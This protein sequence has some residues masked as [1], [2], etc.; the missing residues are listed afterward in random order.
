MDICKFRWCRWKTPTINPIWKRLNVPFGLD[1]V[2]RCTVRT[3]D[4]VERSFDPSQLIRCVS[5]WWV[6]IQKTYFVELKFQK[7]FRK[8]DLI[9]LSLSRC[10]QK[11][12]SEHFIDRLLQT[13]DVDFVNFECDWMWEVRIR[14]GLSS[15]LDIYRYQG[16]ASIVRVRL[17]ILTRLRF[18]GFDSITTI[19]T[20]T[21][22]RTTTA[23]SCPCR[24]M[25]VQMAAH[26]RRSECGGRPMVVVTEMMMM[27]MMI[28][29]RHPPH[30]SKIVSMIACR[31]P[32]SH[33][34]RIIPRHAES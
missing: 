27:I 1:T 6:D 23:I 20:Q 25:K 13:P 16:R 15:V 18:G 14:W 33:C 2:S 31:Y 7:K 24:T 3:Y 22:L 19:D 12:H 9:Q 29:V 34:Q 8:Y 26:Q 17:I 30:S 28:V 32:L 5:I 10:R 21:V 11:D 4:V